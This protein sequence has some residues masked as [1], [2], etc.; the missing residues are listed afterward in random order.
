MV[1]RDNVSLSLS[2]CVYPLKSLSVLT[3]TLLDNKFDREQGYC[4]SFKNN[5]NESDSTLRHVRNILLVS[6]LT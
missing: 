1:S 6:I 2:L 3:V 5:I 4:T